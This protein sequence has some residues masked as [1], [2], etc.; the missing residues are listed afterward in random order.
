MATVDV[1]ICYQ[2]SMIFEQPKYQHQQIAQMGNWP[3][4]QAT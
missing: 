3:I 2:M 1:F 4:I